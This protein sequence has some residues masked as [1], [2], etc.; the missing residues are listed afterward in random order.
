ML[1]LRHK[2]KKRQSALPTY[3]STMGTASVRSLDETLVDRTP[4]V[5]HRA[6]AGAG[7]LV[8]PGHEKVVYRSTQPQVAM[9]VQNEMYTSANVWELDSTETGTRSRSELESPAM[10]RVSS[11]YVPSAVERGASPHVP[12]VPPVVDD[13]QNRGSGF[14]F[15]FEQ[16]RPVRRNDE[17]H[18]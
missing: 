2:R 5:E 3:Q 1:C 8:V 16:T 6:P 18:F 7:G 4:M 9:P 17:L 10:S 11:P 14:D 13:R 12:L 15:G